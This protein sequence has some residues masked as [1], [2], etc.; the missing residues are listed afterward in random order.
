MEA[1]GLVGCSG[2]ANM[3]GMQCWAVQV[4]LVDFC[5]LAWAAMAQVGLDMGSLVMVNRK[6]AHSNQ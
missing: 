5:L 3:C 6:I 1:F 2:H 4:C